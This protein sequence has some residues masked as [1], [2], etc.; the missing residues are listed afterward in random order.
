MEFEFDPAKELQNSFKHGLSLELA[1]YIFADPYVVVFETSRIEDGEIRFK[2]VGQY[3]GKLHTVVFDWCGPVCR[4]ISLRRRNS[5][6][7][8]SYRNSR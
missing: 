1:D 6:E 7:E 3:S 4:C 5:N 2:A 8:R